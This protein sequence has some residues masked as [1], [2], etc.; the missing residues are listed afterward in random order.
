MKVQGLGLQKIVRSLIAITFILFLSYGQMAQA[1]EIPASKY[2]FPTQDPYLATVLASFTPSTT[3]Y[4]EWPLAYRPERL[5][6]NYPLQKPIIN[7]HVYK[8]KK[9]APLVMIIAG[10]GGNSAST[11]SLGLGDIYI[12]AG[13]NVILLPSNLSWSYTQAVSETGV[14]GYMPRDASEFYQF[15]KWILENA[16]AKGMR[17]DSIVLVG[18]SNGGVM[19]GFLAPIDKKQAQPLFKKILL[20]NPGIDVLYGVQQLDYLNDIVGAG[21][22]QTWK[23]H[24]MGAIY[25]HAGDIT[26]AK[27]PVQALFK[28]LD[29]LKIKNNHI[30]WV[31]G[32]QYRQSLWEIIVSSH[33]VKPRVLKTP[34]SKYKLNAL[35]AEAQSYNFL[36][37]MNSFVIPSL[38]PE[39]QKTDIPY[40]TSLYSQ[41]KDLKNDPRVFV[42]TN[43]D[44]FLLKTED[45]SM[46]KENFGDR[47]FL[48]PYGGHMGNIVVPF[49]VQQ[50]LRVSQ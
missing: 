45:I 8:Q 21:I 31:I 28:M 3:K 44:D 16:K 25:T 7:L 48:Y 49:N 5:K 50:Y 13:Y 39:Q 46:L 11:N 23:N 1:L 36:A 2:P 30:Q 41:M 29:D 38:T 6:L 14:P 42:F 24:I 20:I 18:Y 9:E 32:D 37:Y 10:L 33:F 26:A 40:N 34:Y 22:S 12:K 4:D 17:W 47:L 19:A 35:E 15:T 27:D 43:K